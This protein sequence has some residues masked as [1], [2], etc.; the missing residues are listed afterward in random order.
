MTPHGRGSGAC[1]F[2]KI[3]QGITQAIGFLDRMVKVHEY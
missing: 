3:G 1:G 2:T